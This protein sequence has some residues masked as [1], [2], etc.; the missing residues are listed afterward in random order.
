[1]LYSKSTGRKAWVGID[2][3]N[4]AEETAIYLWGQFNKSTSLLENVSLCRLIT[5]TKE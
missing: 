3:L 4:G 1:M 2:I 5:A